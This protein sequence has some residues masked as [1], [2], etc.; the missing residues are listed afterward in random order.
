MVVKCPKP[1]SKNLTNIFQG[2]IDGQRW[3]T[4]TERNP[5]AKWNAL[6]T[7]GQSPLH[8]ATAANHLVSSS[9]TCREDFWENHAAMGQIVFPCYYIN[10]SD[11]LIIPILLFHI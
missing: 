6:R 8:P 9:P 3:H 4:R 10:M 5:L 11:I 2:T 1:I 7:H